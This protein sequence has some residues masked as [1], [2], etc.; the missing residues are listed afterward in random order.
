MLTSKKLKKIKKSQNITNQIA[1]IIADQ[2]R[3][4]DNVSPRDL[5]I[6]IK[7]KLEYS[8]NFSKKP[9]TH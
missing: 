1:E 7:A 5:A 4:Y 9:N 3:L 8:Y 6:R 2:Q